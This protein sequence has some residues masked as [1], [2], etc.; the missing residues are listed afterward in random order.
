MPCNR[1]NMQ[2]LLNR[3]QRDSCQTFLLHGISRF[4]KN[5]FVAVF[6]INCSRFVAITCLC[7]CFLGSRYTYPFENVESA[8]ML[9]QPLG[10]FPNDLGDH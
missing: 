10:T 1:A 8:K 9:I 7:V 6:V 2:L 5:K 4:A 3:P